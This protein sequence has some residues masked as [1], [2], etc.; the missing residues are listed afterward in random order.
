[1]DVSGEIRNAIITLFPGKELPTG[2]VQK[3]ECAGLS[4]VK[5][6][7]AVVRKRTIPT[8]RPP[9]VC[10]VKAV[11]TEHINKEFN[12]YGCTTL[13]VS[14]PF[15]FFCFLNLYTVGRTPYMG[16]QPFGRRPP[17]HRTTQTQNK[18]TQ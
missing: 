10:E 4:A 2:I 1:M 6:S 18:C 8:K 17:T 12:Y 14:L 9:L 3:T 5:N 11:L 16:D 7:M 15:F 13:C